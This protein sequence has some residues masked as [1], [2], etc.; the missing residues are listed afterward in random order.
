MMSAAGFSGWRVRWA[1]AALAGD[2]RMTARFARP[3]SRSQL[4]SDP[5][6]TVGSA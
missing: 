6:E 1:G 5:R 4:L 2:E 3:V